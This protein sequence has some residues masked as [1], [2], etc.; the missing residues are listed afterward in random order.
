MQ[1]HLFL[2]TDIAAARFDSVFAYASLRVNNLST[3]E[4][5]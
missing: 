2:G 4:T 5:V 3:F 1:V